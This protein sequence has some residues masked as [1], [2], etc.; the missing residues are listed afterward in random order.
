MTN[1]ANAMNSL[2]LKDQMHSKL[3]SAGLTFSSIRVFGAIRCNVHVVCVSRET[4]D[5]W[6]LLLAQVFNAE[7][8]V[9]S[10]VWNA[11]ENHGTSLRPTKRNGWL[12]AVAA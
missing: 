5:K 4:A 7:P 10:H 1:G 6:A 3:I 2:S 12:V 11:E 8:S 9:T